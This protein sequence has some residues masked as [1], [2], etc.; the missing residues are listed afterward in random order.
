MLTQ[1]ALII[2]LNL[3]VDAYVPLSFGDEDRD[4][5]VA[6]F[7]DVGSGLDSRQYL[8]ECMASQPSTRSFRVTVV[9]ASGFQSL[10]AS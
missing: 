1:P 5:Q 7:P 10:Q 6:T 3:D 9:K 8:M 4:T 2:N